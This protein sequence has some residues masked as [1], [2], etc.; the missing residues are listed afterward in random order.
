[1]H[2]ST[3]VFGFYVIYVFLIWII[4]FFQAYVV[5]NLCCWEFAI[6]C[7]FTFQCMWFCLVCY[8][9]LHY[10]PE[11]CLGSDGRVGTSN[12]VLF[13]AVR[14]SAGPL[15]HGAPRRLCLHERHLYVSAPL[16]A[17]DLKGCT[18]Q[19]YCCGL[20]NCLLLVPL[21]NAVCHTPFWAY[22]IDL[23]C[24]RFILTV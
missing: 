13:L 11:I 12:A 15:L 19:S 5:F 8:Q 9:I 14:R 23:C 24:S 17:N 20:Q 1:M 16:A 22:S 4:F 3:F 7:L 10:C 2:A 21:I 18:V 6:P